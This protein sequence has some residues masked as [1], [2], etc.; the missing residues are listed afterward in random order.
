MILNFNMPVSSQDQARLLQFVYG[1]AHQ[2]KMKQWSVQ[3]HIACVFRGTQHKTK[4]KQV[5][6]I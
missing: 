1:L 6:N 4:Q 2:S 5:N 3:M